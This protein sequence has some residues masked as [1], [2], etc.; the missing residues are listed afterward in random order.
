MRGI[1]TEGVLD[2]DHR[3]MGMLLAKSFQPATSGIALAII[4]NGPLDG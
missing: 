3:Q 1:G 2:D 4:L